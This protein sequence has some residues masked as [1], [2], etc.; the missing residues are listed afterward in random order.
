MIDL[1]PLVDAVG[2]T[3][4]V[5]VAGTSTRE[6][7]VPGVRCVTAPTG[8]DWFQ[9]DEMTI[10]CGA[11]TPVAEV[12][13]AV[14]EYG[15]YVNLPDGG[16]VGGALAMGRSGLLRLGRGPVRDVLLQARYVSA[17]GEV[18]TAGGPTVKN[19][20]GFDLCRLL[21]GSRGT[22]GVIGDV[23]LRTRPLPVVTAWFVAPAGTDPVALAASLYRPAAV[24]WDGSTTWVCLHGHAADVAE[25]SDRHGLATADGP[26]LLPTGGRW[27]IRPSEVARLDRSHHFVAEVG[28]GVVH[29][30]H[31]PPE[32][33]IA[34][35]VAALHRRIKDELD[36]TGRLSPG[37]AVL[38]GG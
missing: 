28:V 6:G 24:L 17:A 30:E 4:Q 8:I 9:P 34:P 1:A 3:G 13:A 12:Q 37:R 15:Q 33:P 25:E 32:R 21:V 11:G 16:T 20:T 29:H 22:L 5:T 2:P 35:G 23:I 31:P 18:V 14:A 36:P 26:P 19:V 38:G 10:C 27:S 7:G